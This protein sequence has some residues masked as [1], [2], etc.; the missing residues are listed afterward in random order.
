MVNENQTK[1]LCSLWHH[2]RIEYYFK[3]NKW[4]QIYEGYSNRYFV[5]RYILITNFNMANLQGHSMTR[6]F[7]IINIIHPIST[8]A[9]KIIN[10]ILFCTGTYTIQYPY[11]SKYLFTAENVPLKRKRKKK[12][13]S[14][15]NSTF[16]SHVRNVVSWAVCVTWY[17][18]ICYYHLKKFE[19]QKHSWYMNM[20]LCLSY[21]GLETSLYTPN[22]LRCRLLQVLKV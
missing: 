16:S 11:S 17:V 6:I 20:Y 22:L 12:R 7:E 8:C 13:L 4:E 10:A 21:I 2:I 3:C 14:S 1:W 15:G 19:W 18:E 9:Y 5:I